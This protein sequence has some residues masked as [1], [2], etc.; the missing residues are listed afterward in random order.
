MRELLILISWVL[1]IASAEKG[2][3]SAKRLNSS[4]LI[5]AKM[6]MI[7]ISLIQ[8]NLRPFGIKNRTNVHPVDKLI[9]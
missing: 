8:Q 7:E 9:F 3:V 5:L 6:C 2:L 4:S 1:K